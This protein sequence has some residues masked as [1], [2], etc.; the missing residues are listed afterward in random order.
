MNFQEDMN[1]WIFVIK[2]SDNEF[3]NR[4]KNKQWPIYH[5]TRNRKKISID[6]QVLFYKAGNDGQRFLGNAKIKTNLKK[7]TMWDYSLELD[8][9]SIWKKSVLIKPLISD[10]DFITNKNNWG[11]YFQGGVISISSKDFNTITTQN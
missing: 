10:L 7:N 8:E 2:D 3:Q 1:L 6:D 4:I 9:I 5:R 11:V